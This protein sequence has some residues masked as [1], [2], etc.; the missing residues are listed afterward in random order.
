[1]IDFVGD[2]WK[3]LI[4]WSIALLGIF[5]TAV[6]R[7]KLWDERRKSKNRAT[8]KYKEGIALELAAINLAIAKRSEDHDKLRGSTI[9]LESEVYGCV[10]ISNRAIQATETLT[11]IIRKK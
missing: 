1:M 8:A 9:I 5:S 4:G 11:N 6:W 10:A 7:Y 3:E 2:N